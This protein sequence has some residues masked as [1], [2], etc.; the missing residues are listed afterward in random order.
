MRFWD[1]WTA[2]TWHVARFGKPEAHGILAKIRSNTGPITTS[3]CTKSANW[4]GAPSRTTHIAHP[5]TC[6]IPRIF[7]TEVVYR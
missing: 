4:L 1:H 7:F 6:E 3:N 5:V 2:R